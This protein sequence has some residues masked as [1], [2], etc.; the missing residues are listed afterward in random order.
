MPSMG[1]YC[2]DV[3]Y[4]EN[5]KNRRAEYRKK[6]IAKGVMDGSLKML[7]LMIRKGL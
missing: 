6:L 7:E 5:I 1:C 2:N 4:Y 3:N